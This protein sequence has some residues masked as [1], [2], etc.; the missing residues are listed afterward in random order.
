MSDPA[1]TVPVADSDADGSAAEGQPSNPR[2]VVE[3]GRLLLDSETLDQAVYQYLPIFGEDGITV[4]D[5]YIEGMND[6]A[7]RLRLATHITEGVLAS[8]MYV[9]LEKALDAA[10]AVWRGEPSMTYHIERRGMVGGQPFVVHY[11]VATMRAG[12]RV[13]QVAV[14]HTAVSELASVDARF[15]LMAESS[16]DGLALL[17]MDPDTD[18]HVVAYANGAALRVEPGMRVGEL[19]PEHLRLFVLDALLELGVQRPVRRYVERELPSRR[20]DLEVVF[21]EVGDGQVMM[22]MHEV[23][24]ADLAKRALARSDRVLAAIG[25]G[26]FG[27]IAVFEPQFRSDELFDLVLTWTSQDRS[28]APRALATSAVLSATD[29]VQL[30]REMLASGD[31]RR[32]GWV[33]IAADDGERGIEFTLVLAGDRF[34]LEFVERTEELATQTALA[35][36]EAGAEAQRRFLSRVSHELR[37]PLNVIHGNS[38]LLGAIPLPE[39][40]VGHVQHIEQGVERMVHVVDDLLLGQLDHGLVRMETS[41][42]STKE[43]LDRIRREAASSSWWVDGALVSG[44]PATDDDG[45]L[46]TDPTYFVGMALMI[47][48]ASVAEQKAIELGSFRRGARAG[49]RLS[50]PERSE[51]VRSVWAP[52]VRHQALPGSGIRL[53]VA[54]GMANLLGVSLELR[55]DPS[56]PGW[57]SLVMLTHVAG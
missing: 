51:V 31:H 47:I 37:T 12:D 26:S 57:K 8:E 54:R 15:R 45:A 25:E 52:F 32:T 39:R 10:S 9:D 2:A 20:A 23:T 7:R 33:S 6:A 35:I 27:T 38:Q 50:A 56:L 17:A 49:V 5:L 34:V 11:E 14:D 43:L 28:G 22:S 3:N 18:A 48:E 21:T 53:A 4:I 13:V 46:D 36:A 42:V 1:N 29:L 16:L 40:A 44:Q 19:L 24:D 30:A 41:R 55:D